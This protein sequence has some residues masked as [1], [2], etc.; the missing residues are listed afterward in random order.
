LAGIVF[1]SHANREVKFH[2]IY[3]KLYVGL[4]YE[5]IG[6]VFGKSPQTISNWVHHYLHTG[7]VLHTSV[8]Q[9]RK[10]YSEHRQWI[11]KFVHHYP[12][13]HL[14]EI[15]DAFASSFFY[16]S[17]TTIYSVLVEGGYTKKV[18]ETCALEIQQKEVIH[19]TLEINFVHP[20]PFQLLFLD[21]V[22]IDSRSMK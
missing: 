1:S 3:V 10:V 12:L 9:S 14:V 5:Q 18:I 15:C 4:S 13:S 11:L 2:A 21:E 17:L 20:L 8:D 22:S 7:D 19:Y 6:I 16:L